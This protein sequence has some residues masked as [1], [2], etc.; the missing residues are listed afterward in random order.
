MSSSNVKSCWNPAN[1]CSNCSS[2][3]TI[4][5]WLDYTNPLWYTPLPFWGEYPGLLISPSLMV[6]KSKYQLLSFYQLFRFF[7]EIT[8]LYFSPSSLGRDF[9]NYSSNQYFFILKFLSKKNFR[10]SSKLLINWNAN[11]SSPLE[12]FERSHW[13]LC[14]GFSRWICWRDYVLFLLLLTF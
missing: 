7:F 12:I 2:L 8:S 9:K 3:S 5:L 6:C 14:I 10:V 4:Y 13:R 1:S 11:L